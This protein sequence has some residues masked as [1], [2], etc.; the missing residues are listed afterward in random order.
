MLEIRI[1]IRIRA[2][3]W[4]VME[5]QH[6]SSI[7]FTQLKRSGGNFPGQPW[8]RA[9]YNSPILLVQSNSNTTSATKK[10]L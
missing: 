10:K 7:Q 8:Y 9:S 4:N 2:S 6:F 5:F 3:L 1:S